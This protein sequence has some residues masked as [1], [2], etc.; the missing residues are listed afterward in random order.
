MMEETPEKWTPDLWRRNG[1]V[2][3]L[4]DDYDIQHVLRMSP[5]RFDSTKELEEGRSHAEI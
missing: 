2:F 5:G 1:E 3:P 4:K